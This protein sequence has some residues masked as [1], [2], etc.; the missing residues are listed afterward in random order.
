MPDP[1][2]NYAWDLP[3]VSGDAGSWGTLLNT[4]LNDL[5]D[6]VFTADAVADAALPK[7]GGVMTGHL[8]ILTA[9][10]TGA[11]LTGG[12]GT[13]TLNLDNANYFRFTTGLS[14]AVTL[15]ITNITNYSA[16]ATDIVGVI[17]QLKNAGA[18]SSI[19]Y[20]VDGTT[21][22]ILW[23]DGVAPTYTTS[24]DDV[25]VLYTYNGGTTWMGVIAIQDPS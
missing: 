8:D 6:K 17:V 22:T 12:S 15:D 4:I 20:K 13:K 16:G 1:T 19:T 2:T 24:G 11:T 21:K 14:G 3:D 5:D 23:Q 25:I 9:H 10:T 18:A 7:A